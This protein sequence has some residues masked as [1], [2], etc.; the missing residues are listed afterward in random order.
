VARF[1]RRSGVR[2]GRVMA[3]PHGVCAREL[4]HELVPLGFEALCISRPYPWLARRPLPWLKHPPESSP[5]VGLEPASVVDNG[6]PVLLRRALGDWTDELA[7]RAFLDQPLILYGHHGDVAGGLDQFA[8][9]AGRINGL[10]DVEW[11]SPG[12]IA[13]GNIRTRADGEVL[14]VRMFARRARV[15]VPAGARW[16][17]VEAPALEPQHERDDVSCDGRV[18]APGEAIALPG[19]S[20]V[21]E[22]R[23]VRTGALGPGTVPAP[24]LRYWPITR[25]LMSETR[26]RLTPLYRGT[27]ERMTTR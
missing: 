2:V 1:E 4:A 13:A 25:R 22:L 7:L 15:H 6:L 26:D 12:D 20:R 17:T 21:I 18:A 19:D 3:A 9:L 10:G 27:R 14:H 5:L 24:G 16:L 11:A 23:L 8:A